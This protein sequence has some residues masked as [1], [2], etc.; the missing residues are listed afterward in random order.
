MKIFIRSFLFF[1]LILYNYSFGQTLSKK[2]D[3]V[4][5]GFKDKV[6]EVKQN[7]YRAAQEGENIVP[8]EKYN[9][10]GEC[11]IKFYDENGNK[12][13]W[14]AYSKLND[15]LAFYIIV[16]HNGNQL[17][18]TTTYYPDGKTIT[19]YSY[20]YDEKGKLVEEIDKYKSDSTL[21][22]KTIWKY[23]A[24]G[25]NIEATDYK[26]NGDLSTK[27]TF[28]YDEKGNE[29]Q[30]DMYGIDGK[31]TYVYKWEYDKSGNKIIEEL[32]DFGGK[33]LNSKKT[34]SYD[35]KGNTIEEKDYNST[36][37]LKATIDYKYD[38]D[39]RGNWI[40]RTE[41]DDNTIVFITLREI[42]YF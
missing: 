4:T 22:K 19:W 14:N 11:W 33:F 41:L 24:K 40:K 31:I 18:Q 12:I 20:K 7:C 29:I 37:S 21:E 10:H 39:T 9:P 34:F 17:S 27:S 42:T 38:F 1:T 23:D 2:T 28:E 13:R 6:N 16:N 26:P 32:Y 8:G 15:S 30:C 3:A 35:N 5:D 36:G 25:N